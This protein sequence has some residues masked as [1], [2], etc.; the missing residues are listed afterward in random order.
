MSSNIIFC[1]LLQYYRNINQRIDMFGFI[2]SNR[3]FSL[4]NL[5]LQYLKVDLHSARETE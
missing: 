3:F 5:N 2:L 1:M 4:E